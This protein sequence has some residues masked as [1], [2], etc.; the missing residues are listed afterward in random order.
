MLGANRPAAAAASEPS[1]DEQ[2]EG[3]ESEDDGSGEPTDLDIS[4]DESQVENHDEIHGDVIGDLSEKFQQVVSIE[5]SPVK[6]AT[7][8]KVTITNS[9]GSSAT[10]EVDPERDAQIEDE[11]LPV[12]G[13]KVEEHG[14]PTPP[15][16]VCSPGIWV[17][18]CFGFICF[19][20]FGVL[21]YMCVDLGFGAYPFYTSP[22][23]GGKPPA[24]HLLKQRLLQKVQGSGPVDQLTTLPLDQDDANVTILHFALCLV[25]QAWCESMI[26]KTFEFWTFLWISFIGSQSNSKALAA[27]MGNI[28]QA[29]F[30]NVRGIHA[31]IMYTSSMGDHWRFSMFLIV[32]L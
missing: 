12:L 4:E 24:L 28:E 10:Y 27:K 19:G 1:G 5:D 25:W 13:Q 2:Q 30:T 9:D 11:R 3:V 21:L 32:F 15:P 31:Y 14:P 7:W 8:E 20:G 18:G 29:G 23:P 16:P 17:W 26:Y 6:P 22:V